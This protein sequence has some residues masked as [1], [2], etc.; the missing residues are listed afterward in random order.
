MYRAAKYVKAGGTL[1]YSTCT[2]NRDENDLQIASFLKENREF[3]MTYEKQFLPTEGIDGFYVCKMIK[4]VCN[5]KYPY[6]YINNFDEINGKI[7]R[8]KR[9]L[10]G[11]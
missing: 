6:E 8:N 1:V 2:I 9:K 7:M 11:K 4:R 3:E 5:F 10:R